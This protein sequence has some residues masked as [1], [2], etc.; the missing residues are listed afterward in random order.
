MY[1]YD[2]ILSHITQ[3]IFSTS[4]NLKLYYTKIY[5]AYFSISIVHNNCSV[6]SPFFI[7]PVKFKD[8]NN[9][10]GTKLKNFFRA[11][12]HL[13]PGNGFVGPGDGVPATTNQFQ[14]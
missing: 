9:F 12:H 11:W 6:V 10:F 1:N 7:C 4:H 2:Y 5:V 14:S 13:P 8:L 3:V